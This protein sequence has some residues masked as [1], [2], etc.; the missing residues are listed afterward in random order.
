MRNLFPPASTS[1]IISPYRLVV[2]AF[3]SVAIYGCG[4]QASNQ[5][6]QP[7]TEQPLSAHEV[8]HPQVTVASWYG[9]GFHGHPTS[10][11]EIYNQQALTAASRT[12]PL[13]SHARVTNLKTGKSVVVRINDRG[14][15]VRGRGIDL[16]RAAARRIGVDRRGTATVRVTRIDGPSGEVGDSWAG[17]VKMRNASRITPTDYASSATPPVAESSMVSNPFGPWFMELVS[18]SH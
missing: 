16:S 1:P 14:P 8:G 11:G 2:A 18:P 3:L 13:G 5:R 10:S 4:S 9:P 12:L 17:T 7:L 6:P 15:F